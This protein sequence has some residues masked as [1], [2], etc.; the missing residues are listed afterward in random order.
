MSHVRSLHPEWGF[1]APPQSFTRTIR[2]LIVA[3]ALGAT[4][5]S[6]VM[7]S[8]V[9]RSRDET[10]VAAR[11]L[12][13]QPRPSIPLSAQA[14]P[15]S[16]IESDPTKPALSPAARTKPVTYLAHAQKRTTK[17]HQAEPRLMDDWYRAVG[18]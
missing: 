2:I 9:D 5:G 14:K 3:S 7:L 6:G 13:T 16:I 18:L 4:A 10:S 15:Q 11:T 1:L 8:L 12:A 17:K